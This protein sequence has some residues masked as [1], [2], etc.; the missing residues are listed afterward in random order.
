MRCL[1]CGTETPK[2]G[3]SCPACGALH[4]D[5]PTG[6]TI[7]GKWVIEH[8]LGTGGMGR[9][10]LA[11]HADLNRLFALKVLHHRYLTN[12]NLIK[13]FRAEAMAASRLDHPNVVAI[14]D[15]G[16]DPSGLIFITMEYLRGRSLESIATEHFPLPGE[17]LVPITIQICR[18]LEEAH[19]HQIIHR[20][21]KPE[22]VMVHEDSDPPDAV[23]VL[24]FGLAKAL[25]P[26][27]LGGMSQITVTG[28]TCGTPEYMSPEQARGL[29]LDARSDI[30]SLGV[31]LYRVLT[32]RPPFLGRNPVAVASAHVT[33]PVPPLSTVYPQVQVHLRLEAAIMRCLEKR[34][35]ARFDSARAL[36]HELEEILAEL[37]RH[38]EVPGRTL[39]RGTPPEL[40]PDDDSL[41]ALPTS[42]SL[43]RSE[44][45]STARPPLVPV[46]RSGRGTALDEPVS[47]LRPP[48][49]GQV[50]WIEPPGASSGE[51]DS[52]VLTGGSLKNQPGSNPGAEVPRPP[53]PAPRPSPPHQQQPTPPVLAA[54]PT[55]PPESLSP[56]PATGPSS[57]WE[58]R[59]QQQLPTLTQLNA[60]RPGRPGLRWVL[61]AL[62]LLLGLALAGGYL[63]WQRRNEPVLEVSP[64][65][66]RPEVR[67][68][69]ESGWQ[70]LGLEPAP[71]GW[72][73]GVRT[74]SGAR[75]RLVWPS[76]AHGELGQGS[77][78][79]IGLMGGLSLLQ[80]S[81]TLAG[82][83]ERTPLELRS[84][85]GGLIVV[86]QG[87]GPFEVRLSDRGLD[88]ANRQGAALI[89]TG[90]GQIPV[91]PGRRVSYQPGKPPTY[92]PLKSD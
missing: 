81:I 23:K 47:P 25:D 71:L 5:L 86:L 84:G 13:R 29:E 35:E 39:R 43:P 19:R 26:G 46:P 91:D 83:G 60:A 59:T 40:R 56:G 36:R 87:S 28:S 41:E 51:E 82:I 48:E 80:G 31:L 21:L 78:L 42:A 89:L 65:Q 37:Q 58:L 50:P 4:D 44:P 7:G 38:G 70:E 11:R 16:V 76:G 69:A 20:D 64:L 74:G 15:F 22:N 1:H 68:A 88:V 14:V 61:L 72:Q 30:Y 27:V 45:P 90:S 33:E 79:E 2:P 10:Y 3:A 62:L 73:Q 6:T 32:G 57:D 24:D 52:L 75:A 66:G 92:M 9:V 63:L 53:T 54:R 8:L 77:L 12:R 49:S 34:R 85:Q 55:S 67:L 18:A 17:R